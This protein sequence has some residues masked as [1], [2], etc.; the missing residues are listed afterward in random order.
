MI[1]R[2]KLLFGLILLA[3]A[4]SACTQITVL[5]THTVQAG[6]DSEQDVVWLHKDMVLYRC[7][8]TQ[9]GPVCRAVKESN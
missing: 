2:M 3:A 5:S 4:A 7:S 6:P 9:S 8:D 1:N